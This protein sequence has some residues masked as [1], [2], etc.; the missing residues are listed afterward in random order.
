[1]SQ[2]Y[3]SASC[4]ISAVEPKHSV[5]SVP[6]EQRH[7]WAVNCQYKPYDGEFFRAERDSLLSLE[8]GLPDQ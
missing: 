4:H 1:M 5:L 3:E 6:S 7:G 2:R 8:E